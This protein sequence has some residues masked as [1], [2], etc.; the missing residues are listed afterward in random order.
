[1]EIHRIF[2][3]G[4]HRDVFFGIHFFGF[5]QCY[6]HHP[7]SI[8]PWL[9]F[10]HISTIP[11]CKVYHWGKPTL[12]GNGI[13]SIVCAYYLLLSIFWGYWEEPMFVSYQA[14]FSSLD[15]YIYIYIYI[16]TDDPSLPS[17]P[18]TMTKNHLHVNFISLLINRTLYIYVYIHTYVCVFS[19][20]HTHTHIYM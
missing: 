20:T 3:E 2:S 8:S 9:G 5:T 10:Q 7:Q 19:Y 16:C 1:M 13:Q 11:R 4:F 18:G 12:I 6:L 17:F 15:I 14:P